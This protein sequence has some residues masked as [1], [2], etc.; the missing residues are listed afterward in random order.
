MKPSG[1]EPATFRLVAQC[2][3]QLRHRVAFVNIVPLWRN[4]P[5]SDKTLK[6]KKQIVC[7]LSRKNC[8]C[9]KD[10]QEFVICAKRNNPKLRAESKQYTDR[11]VNF[12]VLVK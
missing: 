7:C 1:V 9:V 2:L 12:I 11:D 8:K 6:S 3:N 5:I 10:D 4:C